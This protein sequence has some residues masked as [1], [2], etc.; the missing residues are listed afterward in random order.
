MKTNTVFTRKLLYKVRKSYYQKGNSI[1]FKA[2]YGSNYL[3]L[4]NEENRKGKL[5]IDAGCYF[6]LNQNVPLKNHIEWEIGNEYVY[7]WTTKNS[8]FNVK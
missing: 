2:E 6:A 8:D 7:F 5:F 3:S 4:P 1:I